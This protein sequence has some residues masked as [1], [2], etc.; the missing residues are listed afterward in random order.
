MRILFNG[1][2]SS[3]KSTLAYKLHLYLE[4]QGHETVYLDD[5]VIKRLNN[6]QIAK[7]VDVCASPVAIMV[8]TS[9]YIDA[10]IKFWCVTDPETAWKRDCER[11]EREHASSKSKLNTFIEFWGQYTGQ[12]IQIN[13]N[14]PIDKCM[15]TILC[16]LKKKNLNF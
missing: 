2:P 16:E 1:V 14:E 3:G 4:H 6:D 10:D 13:T 7:I 15:E 11:L 5:E 9:P 12:G 8:S